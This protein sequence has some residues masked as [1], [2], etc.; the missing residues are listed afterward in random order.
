[1]KIVTTLRT[2]ATIAVVAT[3][4]AGFSINSNAN[5]RSQSMALHFNLNRE[6]GKSQL[7]P[8][9]LARYQDLPFPAD[10][11]LAEYVW[12]DAVGNLRSKTRTLPL[13]KV[14][15]YKSGY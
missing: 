6:T 7:D 4:V 13:S 10:R 5:L 12:V 8:A 2:F 9:V 1:M 11:V 15:Q 3:D 14:R